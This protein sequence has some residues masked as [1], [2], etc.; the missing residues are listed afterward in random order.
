MLNEH[1]IKALI[2]S[3][4]ALS[5]SMRQWS[6]SKKVNPSMVS[7]VMQG[8]ISITPGLARAMGYRRVVRFERITNDD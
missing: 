3:Q 4:L 8:K 1:E 7:Q 2:K 6:Y 5:A